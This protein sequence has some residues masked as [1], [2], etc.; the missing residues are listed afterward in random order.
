MSGTQLK[1][2]RSFKGLRKYEDREALP[3]EYL[4]HVEVTSAK[5]FCAISF[6]NNEEGERIVVSDCDSSE[7]RT[8]TL[9][10][11]DIARM[12]DVPLRVIVVDESIEDLELE[13]VE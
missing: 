8:L 7:F 11:R 12:L 6:C 5:D 1:A 10:A 13:N 3:K 2:V 4:K 9:F